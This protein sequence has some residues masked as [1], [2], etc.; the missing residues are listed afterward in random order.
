MCI[1]DGLQF[2]SVKQNFLI[3]LKDAFRVESIIQKTSDCGRYAHSYKRVD[4]LEHYGW[5]PES[6]IYWGSHNLLT[7]GM[8]IFLVVI[9]ERF[10]HFSYRIDAPGSRPGWSMLMKSQNG[11]IV[12][13]AC[14]E[15]SHQITFVNFPKMLCP[16]SILLNGTSGINS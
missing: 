6:L 10:C 12:G 4:L 5:L 16:I 8:K 13:H 3:S 7:L 1:L 14:L 15:F 9:L 2:L 11:Q